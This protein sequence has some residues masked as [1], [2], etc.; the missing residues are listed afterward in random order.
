MNKWFGLLIVVVFAVAG[1]MASR[2]SVVQIGKSPRATGRAIILLHGHGA[3]PED[4]EWLAKALQQLDSR[5]TILLAPA[6]YR[7]GMSGR[8]W[9]PSTSAPSKAEYLKI[10][11]E[12][13]AVDRAVVDDVVKNLLKSG[14]SSSQIFIGGFSQ[15][16]SV[17]LDYILHS[18]PE[19]VPGGLIS[20]SG[21]AQDFDLEPLK[22][23][24][25]FKAF[26][27]H[28]LKDSVIGSSNTRKVEKALSLAKHKVF[29]VYFQ[30][31]HEIPREVIGK[32]GEFL[33]QN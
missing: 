1:F 31:D 15:G 13:R 17:A 21:G 28:G 7:A 2:V 25:P 29:S 26:L 30:G 9:Y 6:P 33:K 27:S 11:D 24:K 18:G 4:L 32:L 10:L 12:Q 19:N 20:L 22:N 16:A 14:V 5:W 8:S 3:T 23:I